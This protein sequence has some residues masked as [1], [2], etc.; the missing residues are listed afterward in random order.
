MEDLK[1]SSWKNSFVV[2]HNCDSIDGWDG[3]L[4]FVRKGNKGISSV[5]RE[6]E[7]KKEKRI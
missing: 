6:K 5:S 2:V 7:K 4:F 1:F 3:N